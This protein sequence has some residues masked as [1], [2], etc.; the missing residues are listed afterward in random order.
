[1]G[2]DRVQLES[3]VTPAPLAGEML[4][5]L[6]V[7]G[8]CGTDLFKLTSGS[9]EPGTVLGHEVVG[10]VISLGA[11]VKK[12]SIGDR[13]AVPHH[14]PCGKCIYC[15]RDCSTM[16]TSFRENLLS[17]GGFA[18]KILVRSRAAAMSA[19]KIPESVSD[20]S[21][22]FME[23]AACVLRGILKAGLTND[24]TVVIFGSGSMGLLHA[25]VLRAIFSHLSIV[26]LDPKKERLKHACGLGFNNVAR[27]ELQAKEIIASLNGGIGAD[28]V[29][30]TVGGSNV[31]NSA[32]SLSRHGGAILLF[33]H[34]REGEKSSFVLNEL[35]KYE[36]RIFGTY[37]G[38]LIEQEQIFELLSSGKLDPT[39]LITHKLSLYNFEEGVELVRKQ[40]A[41]KVLFTPTD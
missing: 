1:M 25:L 30:D 12:F 14:V 24:G 41:L 23:P 32:L 8:F 17:P 29:F 13:V 7:V 39:S 36:R 26:I 6:R 19:R 16:C 22:V 20:D 5:G 15:M 2:G 3:R 40:K 4:L 31:L 35:F 37:S 18:N 11:G 27:S 9:I 28:A 38:A 10:E 34:A 21:A 33:A